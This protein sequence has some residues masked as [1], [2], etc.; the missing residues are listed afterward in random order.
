MK[1]TVKVVPYSRKEA[2]EKTSEDNFTVRV[3]AIP[4]D[5]EANKRVLELLSHYF[6]VP[7]TK[8]TLLRG[9]KSRHKI[10]EVS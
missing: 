10:F 8:I 9:H 3:N 2:V 6:Q 1:I 7:K 5:G 4:N